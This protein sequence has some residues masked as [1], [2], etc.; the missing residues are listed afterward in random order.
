MDARALFLYQHDNIVV[1]ISVNSII[2]CFV[3]NTGS[4]V[5]E[6]PIPILPRTLIRPESDLIWSVSEDGSFDPLQ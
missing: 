2:Y 5:T 6:P 3:L 4:P 1:V